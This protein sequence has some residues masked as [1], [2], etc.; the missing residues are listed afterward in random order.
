MNTNGHYPEPAVLDA[1]LDGL[2]DDSRRSA[3]EERIRRDPQLRREIETQHA[4]DAALSRLFVPPATE[5]LNSGF[6]QMLAKEIE[7]RPG[8]R[9]FWFRKPLAAA[10]VLALATVSVWLNRDLLWPTASPMEYK[11]QPFRTMVEAYQF[12]VE[13]Q[14]KP[15]WVCKNDRQFAAIFRS[16]FGQALLL[17]ARP[18]G[19]TAG[20]IGYRNVITPKTVVVLG[21]V[22]DEPVTVFVDRADADRGQT[23]PPD[24]KLKFYR[25]QIGHLVL[26]EVSRLDAPHLLELFH[27]PDDPSSR[28]PVP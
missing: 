6:V 7:H 17:A 25:R 2:L 28:R 21:K 14:L 24:S 20:G 19:I 16:T 12:E 22:S 11:P 10:A 27:D 5:E 3:F 9:I 8:P 4:I 15:D 13:N 23:L 1:Y 26:Y 18:A